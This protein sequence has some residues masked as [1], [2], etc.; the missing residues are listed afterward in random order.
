MDIN[1]FSEKLN[2]HIRPQTF[3]VAIRMLKEGEPLP[4]KTRRVKKDMNLE[5]AIC[6]GISM[7]R[8]YGWTV[9]MG[10]EDINCP[11]TKIAFGFEKAG[12]H[13]FNG[14]ACCGMYTET[15]GAGAKT[16][17]ATP[18]FP[19]K[20]YSSIIVSPLSSGKFEPD[21]ICIYAS[22]AQVMRLLV[23]ALYNKGGYLTSRF[24]GRIDCAD[25]VIE[26]MTTQECQVILPCYGDRIFAQTQDTEMA[27]TIPVSKI[28]EI[29]DGLEG[30]HKGGI[31]YP[32]PSFL[33]YE[34]QFPEHYKLVEKDWGK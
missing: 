11:L 8:K 6:Q 21:V 14:E 13:Y 17:Q 22:S 5:I 19:Y 33:R 30:T 7:A 20:K 32:I 23:A 25:I 12:E 29:A 18:K 9:A 4:D 24:S 2:Y 31:R 15:L 34:G 27:F 28:D 3:P 10:S 16:E 1:K 26:A